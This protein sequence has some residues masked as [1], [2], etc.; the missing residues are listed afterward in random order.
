[1]Q[2]RFMI[3]HFLH[4][5]STAIASSESIVRKAVLLAL[6]CCYGCPYRI[7]EVSAYC[8]LLYA[9][10]INIYMHIKTDIL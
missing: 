2:D 6:L 1:M 3:L 10:F 8:T 4:T 9:Y 5:V 7:T